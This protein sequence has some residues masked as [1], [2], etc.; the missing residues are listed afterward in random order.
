[1]CKW[2]RSDIP[3]IKSSNPKG[4]ISMLKTLYLATDNKLDTDLK[5]VSNFKNDRLRQI[6]PLFLYENDG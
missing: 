4:K 5:K 6:D 1:M 3:F 2:V